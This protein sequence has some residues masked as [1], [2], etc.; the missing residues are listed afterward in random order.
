MRKAV[1]KKTAQKKDSVNRGEVFISV[2][3]KDMT[4]FNISLEKATS[5]KEQIFVFGKFEPNQLKKFDPIKEQCQKN[6]K[7]MAQKFE[8]KDLYF[9]DCLQAL[10]SKANEDRI[11]STKKEID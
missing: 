3:D 2:K 9:E 7:V 10:R 6:Q 4:L 5:I 8:L 11:E 1:L